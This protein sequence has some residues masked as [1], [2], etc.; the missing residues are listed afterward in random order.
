MKIK[1]ILYTIKQR[2][3]RY[4]KRLF[5]GPF[6]KSS[7]KYWVQKIP[8]KNIEERLSFLIDYC[9]NKDVLHI[10]CTDWPIFNP[11]NNLHI[12]LAK[13]TKILHGFDVDVEGIELLKNYVNQSYFSDFDDLYDQ[14]YDVCLVPE[15][16][17]H[18]DNVK[19]FLVNIS[20]IKASKFI[21]TTPNCFAPGIHKR[22]YRGKDFFIE[23]V[24]PDHNCWF[25]PY[26]LKNQIEKYS[27]L[28]VLNIFL[29]E[30]G[31]TICCEAIKD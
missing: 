11:A 29:I 20:K 24:H 7:N 3:K 28:K 30:N 10:G 4:F 13:H 31:K 25:S 15:T 27:S 14:N 22:N 18:V 23:L 17:E 8:I 1:K 6:Y 9:H 12:E 16:I 5:S 21:F 19:D 26:T 2:L